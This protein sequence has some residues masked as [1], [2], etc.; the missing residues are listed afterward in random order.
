[1]KNNQS[2]I[3]C[4]DLCADLFAFPSDDWCEKYSKLRKF[5]NS[6]F[7]ELF[8][9][10]SNFKF[11]NLKEPNLDEIIGNYINYFDL[12][13][14]KFG[15][16]LLASVWLDNKAFGENYDKICKF[17]EFCGYKIEKNCEH[18]SNLVAF[19]AIL[20]ENSEFEKFNKF[21]KFLSW[22]GKLRTNLANLPNLV[23]FEF[24]LCFTEFLIS[25]L[26][27]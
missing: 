1:M 16:S 25:N 10:F 19:C 21:C 8:D 20:V 12:N 7:S 5:A 13:S 24:I 18:I 3:D 11:C 27:D 14:A 4:L 2:L 26:K 23:H 15:T 22:F 6:E 9:E 17:Y